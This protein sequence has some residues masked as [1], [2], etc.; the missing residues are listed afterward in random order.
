MPLALPGRSPP[1][2]PTCAF[3]KPPAVLPHKRAC[4]W[5]WW[6]PA[7]SACG[8]AFLL[9]QEC[10]PPYQDAHR[11]AALPAHLRSLLPP[12][13][14][15]VNGGSGPLIPPAAPCSFYHKDATCP[16]RTP[17]ALPARSRSLLSLHKITHQWWWWSADSAC[18][19]TFFLPQECHLPYQDAHRP[20]ACQRVQEASSPCTR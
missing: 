10:L 19:A 12:T 3:E 6:W 16:T 2:R 11:P 8:A 9:P 7:D 18:G 13:K 5:W 14:W 17:A 1:R 15:R 4:Q 20:A